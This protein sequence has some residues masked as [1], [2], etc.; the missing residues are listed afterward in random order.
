MARA[1][2]DL[3]AARRRDPFSSAGQMTALK[4]IIE[5]TYPGAIDRACARAEAEAFEAKFL[6][7]VPAWAK[8]YVAKYGGANVS[9]LRIKQSRSPHRTGTS[10][11]CLYSTGEIQ[12][13]FAVDGDENEQKM[14]VLHEI[15]HAN[16]PGGHDD[17]FYAEWRR[18]L[19]AEGLYR[20]AVK[21]GRFGTRRA[22]K[23]RRAA[24]PRK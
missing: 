24:I 14:S 16:K 13:T 11:W 1:A 18:L 6:G 23:L 22:N 10:G 21:S 15:A 5:E 17:R 8:R 12:L 4:R 2:I 20:E 19:A 9:T 7:K 3:L